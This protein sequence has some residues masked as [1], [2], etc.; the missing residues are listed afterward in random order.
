MAEPS[1]T[2]GT[3]TIETDDDAF[4]VGDVGARLWINNGRGLIT[5][6]TSARKVTVS[7]TTDLDDDNPADGGTWGFGQEMTT[8]SGLD[9]LE[10][11]E[12]DIFGDLKDLGTATVSDG[13]SISPKPVPSRSSA[14]MSARGGSR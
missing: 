9:H 4:V 3:I 2:T 6:Y 8:I 5:A 10:G 1:G 7:L 12:V 14:V 13:K 11:V